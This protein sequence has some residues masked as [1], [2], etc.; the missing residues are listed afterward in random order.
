[1]ALFFGDDAPPHPSPPLPSPP[2]PFF[3]FFILFYLSQ[4]TKVIEQSKYR[5]LWTSEP[6][7]NTLPYLGNTHLLILIS[8]IA[9]FTLGCLIG[10]CSQKSSVDWGEDFVC[11]SMIK[12][13]SVSAPTNSLSWPCSRIG[14]F[15]ISTTDT[16]GQIIL[17]WRL[18]CALKGVYQYP[19]ALWLDA[20]IAPLHTQRC[21][22]LKMCPDMDRWFCGGSIAPGWEP[23]LWEEVSGDLLFLHFL[24]RWLWQTFQVWLLHLQIMYLFSQ[25]D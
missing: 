6:T 17:C 24:T 10:K 2:I 21:D 5:Q 20:S 3:L 9:S 25:V 8:V 19:W 16:L 12:A 13:I 4:K 23:L 11:I 1:M 7:L 18:S 15:N 22:K 14:F